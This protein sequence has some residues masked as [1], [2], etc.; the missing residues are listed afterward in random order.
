[1]VPLCW[2]R[3][4]RQ[5]FPRLARLAIA[6]VDE[7]DRQLPPR[8]LGALSSLPR[9]LGSINAVTAAV[10]GGGKSRHSEAASSFGDRLP[11]TVA[12]A[13]ANAGGVKEG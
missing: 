13:S 2:H 9:P 7:T 6:Q 8:P 12:L 1:M 3:F 4:T 11:L 10:S 5:G